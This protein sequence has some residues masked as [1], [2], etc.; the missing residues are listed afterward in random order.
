MSA[1]Q[2][3]LAA[4]EEVVSQEEPHA[5]HDINIVADPSQL[6]TVRAPTSPR[7]VC[8]DCD[9]LHSSLQAYTSSNANPVMG[10][11]GAMP[12]EAE[13]VSHEERRAEPDIDIIANPGQLFFVRTPNAPPEPCQPWTAGL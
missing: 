3:A 13:A 6:T 12:A 9:C 2:G 8:L 1:R 10:R 5:E 11:Q 4:E 7:G